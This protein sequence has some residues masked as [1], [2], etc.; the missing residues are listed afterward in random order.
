MSCGTE[1]NF[2]KQLYKDIETQQISYTDP[3]KFIK[4]KNLQ[5]I[6]LNI[7]RNL[8]NETDFPIESSLG[9]IYLI[10]GVNILCMYCCYDSKC[11][12]QWICKTGIYNKAVGDP[13]QLEYFTDGVRVLFSLDTAQYLMLQFVQSGFDMYVYQ[14]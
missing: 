3:K 8:I 5:K 6:K 2:I 9:S 1:S 10:K 7:Q 14:N 11:T 12:S 4:H 13:E